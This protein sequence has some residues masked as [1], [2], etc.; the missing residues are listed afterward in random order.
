MI[1]Q[2]LVDMLLKTD[3][4]KPVAI[5]IDCKQYQQPAGLFY[6]DKV[7]EMPYNNMV[8]PEKSMI[9]LYSEGFFSLVGMEKI[10]KP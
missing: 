2:E 3:L 10:V 1:G 8:S 7:A 6:L 4:K 9:I 5:L